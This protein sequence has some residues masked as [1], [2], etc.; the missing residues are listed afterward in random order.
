MSSMRVGPSMGRI[1]HVG[2]ETI[3]IIDEQGN[4]REVSM[5]E[6]RR[7]MARGLG[8][9]E[10]N[11]RYVGVRKLDGEPWVV[12]LATEPPLVLH[13][14]SYEAAYDELLTPLARSGLQTFDYT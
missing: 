3:K 1:V 11:C 5:L 4:E 10:E 6:C 8:R 2:P 9:R 12:G 7:R 14:E 13:F